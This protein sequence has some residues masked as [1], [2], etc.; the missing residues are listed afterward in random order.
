[1]HRLTSLLFAVATST[2]LFAGELDGR[3]QADLAGANTVLDLQQQ[4]QVVTG[5]YSENGT[6]QLDLHGQYDGQV[7]NAEIVL[8]Q[9]NQVIATLAAT[10][11][12][13]QLNARL[14]AHDP[15]SGQVLERQALFQRSP[16]SFA[17]FNTVLTLHLTPDGRVEQWSRSVGGGSDWSYDSDGTLQYAGQ[18]QTADGVLLVRP[19]GSTDYQPATRYRFS[20]PY[21][22]TE[23]Q[24]GRKIWQRR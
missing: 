1:M 8:P 9:T 11:G 16:S 20:D 24:G 13:D 3:F 7:L 22:V 23:D 5:R 19:D 17:S 21:L 12:N 15:V 18:W 4:G 14:A 6:L 10:Y 2:P